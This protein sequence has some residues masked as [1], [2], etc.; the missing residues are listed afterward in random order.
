MGGKR[1]EPIEAYPRFW[2]L[3]PM[4]KQAWETLRI[5]TWTEAFDLVKKELEKVLERDVLPATLQK[6]STERRMT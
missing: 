6:F 3:N 5:P 4:K 2:N 1:E